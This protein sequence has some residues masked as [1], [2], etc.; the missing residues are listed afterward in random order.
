[1]RRSLILHAIYSSRPVFLVERRAKKIVNK[2]ALQHALGLRVDS[3]VPLFG[4]VA[5]L[6]DQKGIG[7][8]LANM[9]RWLKR[10]NAQFV[11]LGKGLPK[12][13]QALTRI[14]EKFPSCVAAR[15]I[16]SERFSHQIYAG[17]DFF[18]M[19]SLF[20]PSGLGQMIAMRYGTIPIVRDTGGLHDSVRHM[21]TGIVFKKPNA[22]ELNA[23]VQTA[24]TIYSKKEVFEKMRKNCMKENFDFST[25]AREYKK[26]YNHVR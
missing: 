19:P 22:K 3:A 8:M 24:L 5:R 10:T 17:S 25:S 26:L 9:H 18:F 11:F 14:A 23:A 15:I 4:M 13:E 7:L 1:M 6:T 12:Y 2:L 16:F 21:Q 20:E